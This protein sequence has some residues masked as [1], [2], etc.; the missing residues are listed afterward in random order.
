MKK[1]TSMAIKTTVMAV[2]FSTSLM[3]T[4]AQAHSSLDL[5]I[6]VQLLLLNSVFDHGHGHHH[7]SVTRKQIRHNDGRHS[8]YGHHKPRR[9]SYSREGY[10]DKRH[11]RHR[12]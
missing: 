3:S 1:T 11:S 12:Y 9:H 7:Y 10:R 2:V 5:S 4:G 6:P 8:G